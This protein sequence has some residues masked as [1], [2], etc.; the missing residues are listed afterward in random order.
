M[1]FLPT[2]F[3]HLSA[4]VMLDA[5]PGNFETVRQLLGHKSL[6]TT[7]G[8]YAGI[9]SRRAGRHQQRLIEEAL[10]AEM[11]AASFAGTFRTF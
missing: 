3:R 10:A 11:R 6:R 8:A 7:V 5:Q 1:S 9:D 2:K 4:K